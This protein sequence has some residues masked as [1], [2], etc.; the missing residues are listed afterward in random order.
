[1]NKGLSL[2]TG[3][4]VWFINAGDE[5]YEPTTLENLIPYFQKNAD[6]V[7][8]DTIHVDESRKKLG[9]RKKRPPKNFTW[10]SFRMG[11][12]VCHQS[13]LVSR[14]IVPNY[15]MQYKICAD[16]EWVIQTMK[17]AQVI[18]NSQQI[19]SRFLVG[20]FSKQHEK[21]AWKERFI[22][23]QKNYGLLQTLLF[24]IFIVFRYIFK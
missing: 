17:R 22:I 14:K 15:D 7:Y 10:K 18:C 5:I 9:L 21:K 6:V 19:L 23:M 2:A 11:M 12:M 20:G 1:M 3:D 16:I 13:I 4:Y 24:H 8:G